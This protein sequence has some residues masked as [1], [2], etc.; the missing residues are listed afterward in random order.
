MEN[1]PHTIAE[2]PHITEYKYFLPKSGIGN[3]E[4][5][6]QKT[7]TNS[8]VIIGANGSGKSQLGAWMEKNRLN[9]VHR[10]G[11]QRSLKF[12]TYV[13]QKSYEQAT[14]YLLYGDEN[15]QINHDARWGKE[16]LNG[17][18]VPQYTTGLLNDFEHALSAILAKLHNEQREYI[19]NCKQ[20]E[21]DHMPHDPVPTMVVDILVEIWKQVFPHRQISLNDGKVMA[22]MECR[23]EPIEYE[24]KAMSDGERV[25]LYVI[26]QALAIPES[27]T[28][29]IDEPELHLHRS[30]MNR[31]WKAIEKQR[32]DCLFIYLTHDTQ[33]A[34]N[35]TRSDKIWA[36]SYDG[37]NWTWEI[38]QESELPEQLLLDILGNR[39]PVIFVEGANGSYDF[40]L[41]S[42]IYK[43]YYVIP[44]GSCIEV[45]ER[46]KAMKKAAQLHH[47]EVF[48]IIDRDFRSDIEIAALEQYNIFSLKIAEVE[49]LFITQEIL[50]IINQYLALADETAID[51]IMNFVMRTKYANMKNQQIRLASISE[52]KYQLSILDISDTQTDEEVLLAIKEI[53]L[54]NIRAIIT[55][56]YQEADGKYMD[57]LLILND[58]S[59]V[60]SIGHFFGLNDDKYCDLVLRLV[61]GEKEAAIREALNPYLPS[62]IPFEI[63]TNPIAI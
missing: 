37:N 57:I 3:N 63:D 44:C 41:Y 6:E 55:S 4:P 15:K 30:I 35:H 50:G 25:A 26:A 17:N 54:E 43:N 19:I 53:D 49:N 20:H 24:G 42:A 45:I 23:D 27:K 8:I 18:Y 10:I 21:N 1:T 28:I 61:H 32:P 5:Q 33:F 22:I 59:I 51:R 56:K 48:G 46:T 7:R 31:L 14:K 38:V 9:E 13:P 29:I 16:F 2:V 34:A 62:E 12:S 11:A 40:T 47:L 52:I 58:K 39:K 36:K 60:N